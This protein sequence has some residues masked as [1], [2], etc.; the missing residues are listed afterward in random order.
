MD[1]RNFNFQTDSYINLS[2]EWEFYWLKFLTPD[3]FINGKTNN[4]DFIKV[5][6]LW[7]NHKHDTK[8]LT[9]EGYATYRLSVLLN[10]NSEIALSLRFLEVSSAF[11]IFING[12]EYKNYG[13]VSTSY[14]FEKPVLFPQYLDFI[15]Q[16]ETL[17]IVLHVSNFHHRKG[18][19]FKK[20]Q[21]GSTE[22]IR[23]QWSKNIAFEFTIFGAILIMGL[24]HLG[25]F[26][27]RHQDLSPLFFGLFCIIMAVRVIFTGEKLFMIFHPEFPYELMVKL[28]FFSIYISAPFFVL[29]FYSLFREYFN[30]Y[31]LFLFGF[32]CIFFNLA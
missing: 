7:P 29:F 8:T 25:L 17:N 21:L 15:Q 18:G 20:I 3:D 6:L 26:L 9:N 5:P 30:K 28:D 12:K 23:K 11:K 2:G 31:I 14:E 27:L 32:T 19:I 13:A 22:V 1:L 10:K 4:P 16:G 24:Y